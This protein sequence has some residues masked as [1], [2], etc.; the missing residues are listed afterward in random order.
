MS[1][2]PVPIAGK[3][4]TLLRLSRGDELM[5]IPV[6]LPG[7]PTI[8]APAV[9]AVNRTA[10]LVNEQ[11]YLLREQTGSRDWFAS[12]I[13]AVLLLVAALWAAAF[14]LAATGIGRRRP[15]RGP[16]ARRGRPALSPA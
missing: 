14:A 7:D 8:P 2:E 12:T 15:V 5:A 1:G 6:Y 3:W 10:P 11:R 16:S 13:D 4:K 9:P